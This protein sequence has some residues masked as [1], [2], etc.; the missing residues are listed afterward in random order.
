[1]LSAL[2]TA[3]FLSAGVSAPARVEPASFCLNCQ[4]HAPY[5]EDA[6]QSP[7]PNDE[8]GLQ[9]AEVK[10]YSDWL[11][12]LMGRTGIKISKK[13]VKELEDDV[14]IGSGYV[15]TVE[16]EE[17]VSKDEAMIA[18]VQSVGGRI[19]DVAAT[20]KVKCTWGDDQLNPF[21][22]RFKVLE[23]KDV[24]AFSIPGGYIFVYEG[25]LRFVE[26]DDELAA[27]LAH[28]VSHASLRHLAWML[29]EQSRF[30][31]WSLPMILIAI[32]SGGETTGGLLTLN[33][34]AKQATQSGWSVK[35]EKAADR[36]GF[37]YMRAAGYDPVAA[38]TF[39][40]RLAGIQKAQEGIDLGIFRTHPPSRERA[41]QITLYL[42]EARLPI[43]RSLV[44]SSFRVALEVIGG[45][46]AVEGVFNRRT[47]F[48]FR[49]PDAHKRAEEAA[50]RLNDFFDQVPELFEL[51]SDGNGGIYGRSRLL[52]RLTPVDTDGDPKK[53]ETAT[54]RSVAVVK[55]SLFTLAYNVWNMRG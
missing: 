31:T 12:E 6:Q 23:G 37:E 35:A 54:L 19:A 51:T 22:Y 26:S 50:K 41:D 1:M 24:N 9:S 38:L 33:Q 17:K 55:Q 40:E 8:R 30:D 5:A 43:K 18:R 44:S 21:R 34:L 3:T 42:N 10:A 32:F 20:L 52:Y 53:L 14:Q 36:G 39:M 47:I 28:E 7:A 4:D 49:G 46:D 27:V 13:H 29:R 25:L 2:L 11:N 15:P 16:K 48:R 45:T